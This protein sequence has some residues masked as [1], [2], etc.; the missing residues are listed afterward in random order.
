M[1]P[2]ITRSRLL[3][4]AI[5]SILLGVTACS[6]HDDVVVPAPIGNGNNVVTVGDTLLLAPTISAERPLNYLWTM[7]GKT[8]GTDSIWKFA[9][10]D[11]GDYSIN[12]KVNNAGGAF[13]YNYNVHV[14]GKYE[15]GFFI[16]NE[17]WFG[18]GTG[19]L[20]FYRY[21]TQQVED[22]V[23]TKANPGKDLKPT[24]STVEY[25]SI[26]NNKLYIL[27]KV[28]G[29]IVQTDAY[30]LK[31]INRVPATGGNDWRAFLG[32]DSTHAL[33]SSS[34]G[35]FPLD[36]KTMT[37]GTPVTSITG[38]VSDLI[39][40][41]NYIFALSSRQGVVVLKSSDTTV[42]KTF[43]GLNCGFTKTP[44]GS[45]WV[46]GGNK[47]VRINPTTLDTTQITLP[48]N[49]TSSA[50]AWHPGSITASTTENTVFV[51]GGSSSWSPN[52]IFKYTVGNGTSVPAPFITLPTGK[53]LYGAGIGFDPIKK[54]LVLTVT[55]SNYVTNDLS[56]YDPAT[57][58]LV[59]N[60]SYT[61]YYFPA[62]LVFRQQ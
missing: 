19:S 22:S 23:F 42:A 16:A 11:R 34:K 1:V 55:S 51:A 28:G 25:S 29:P 10:T 36:L 52:Q 38:E 24:T 61:G 39:K 43:A 27:S 41:G 3:T 5:A 32:T 18:H 37:I 30:S 9:P 49:A 35:L 2:K 44:D 60:N 15:N 56:F 20:S 58:Y 4:G 12:L 17:G 14:Y 21:N 31:E 7:N 8:E 53:M 26:W 6:K 50:G 54:N 62:T 57:G 46:A 59:K 33:I 48:S 45:I 40:G 47:L 13:S